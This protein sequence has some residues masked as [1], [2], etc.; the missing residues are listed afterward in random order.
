MGVIRWAGS[1]PALLLLAAAFCSAQDERRVTS[2]DGRIEFLLSF[3]QPDPGAPFQLAYQ[4]SVRGQL[5]VD[6]SFLGLWIHNQEPILGANLGLTA[7]RIETTEQ[8]H[9]LAAEYMQ[10]GSLGRR[11]TLEVRAYNE[12]V[13]FRYRVPRSLPLDEFLL[14]NEATEF[15]FAQALDPHASLALPFVT[16]QGEAG[17]AGILEVPVPHYPR[18]SLARLDEKTLVSDLAAGKR[19]S[20]A[21]LEAKTP[22]VSPWR[23]LLIGATRERLNESGLLDSLRP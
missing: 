1:A 6:T 10:N 15:S 20:E 12:G 19:N 7:S 5:F 4:V 21:V 23:V 18:L 9:S 2:P 8:Y 11:L 13:A 17:W 14:D 22:L 3:A 16:R